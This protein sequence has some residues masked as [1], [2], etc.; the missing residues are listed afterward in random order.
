MKI[1]ATLGLSVLSRQSCS[2]NPEIEHTISRAKGRRDEGKIDMVLRK[3]NLNHGAYR[4]IPQDTSYSRCIST[5]INQRKPK[6]R[7][8]AHTI[9]L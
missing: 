6:V 2:S 8:I 4:E 9:G 5:K 1:A 3:A 7:T